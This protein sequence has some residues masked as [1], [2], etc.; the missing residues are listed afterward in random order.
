M[1]W[2]KIANIYFSLTFHEG[3]GLVLGD[4]LPWVSH[5]PT[6]LA[7]CAKPLRPW[8]FFTQPF[9]RD[10][11]AVSNL[12]RGGNFYLWGKEQACSLFAMKWWD[13]KVSVPLLECNLLCFQASTWTPSHVWEC[14]NGDSGNPHKHADTLA[15]VFC[16]TQELSVFC[17]H[18]WN[19]QVNILAWK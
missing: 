2:H 3:W 1:Q 11:S 17:Q 7:G 16:L 19:W 8:S 10:V 6:C 12:D 15:T 9:L 14:G 4:A 13:F 5:V 18:R